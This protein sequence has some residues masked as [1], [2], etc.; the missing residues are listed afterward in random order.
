MQEL[1]D[2]LPHV[3]SKLE[4]ILAEPSIH[5]E[6]EDHNV[7]LKKKALK[8]FQSWVQYGISPE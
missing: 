3:I 6:P 8:C 5:S 4:T 7:N 2:G 1:K